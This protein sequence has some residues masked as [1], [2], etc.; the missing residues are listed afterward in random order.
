M[1]QNKCQPTFFTINSCKPSW[2][3]TFIGANPIFASSSI[4]TWLIFTIVDILIAINIMN[5]SAYQ[6]YMH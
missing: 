4:I 3:N 5:Y 1:K 6:F 2:T